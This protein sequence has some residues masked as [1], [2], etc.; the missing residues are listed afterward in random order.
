[1]LG[2]ANVWLVIATAAALLVYK[3]GDRGALV[4]R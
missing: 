1:L 2:T 4:P 3:L